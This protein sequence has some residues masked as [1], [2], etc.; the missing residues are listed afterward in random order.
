MEEI[1]IY[2]TFNEFINKTVVMV[3][4]G[5]MPLHS[6]VIEKENEESVVADLKVEFGGG[7]PVVVYKHEDEM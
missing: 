6:L 1:K 3:V 5:D 7:D 4:H 2:V